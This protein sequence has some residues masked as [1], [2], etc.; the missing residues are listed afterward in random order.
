MHRG[1]RSACASFGG[2]DEA[3]REPRR[4]AWHGVLPGFLKLPRRTPVWVAAGAVR[5]P[6][7]LPAPQGGDE[8]DRSGALPL[9][10]RHRTAW[11]GVLPRSGGRR[12]GCGWR[13]PLGRGSVAKWRRR[14]GRCGLVPLGM[15]FCREVAAVTGGRLARTA[16]HGVLPRDSDRPA[17]EPALP[18]RRLLLGSGVRA[19]GAR[20][21]HNQAG[22]NGREN[23]NVFHHDS[24]INNGNPIH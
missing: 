16:G 14:H 20:H 15:G 8:P 19:G 17:G 2:R 24:I 10:R 7:A 1:V 9:V 12:R 23:W 21:R 18:M 11:H 6:A 3:S 5:L 22:G 4:T 13:V